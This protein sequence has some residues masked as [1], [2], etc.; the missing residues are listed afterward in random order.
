MDK[1]SREGT[2]PQKLE[3]DEIR[4]I[5]ALESRTFA[6]RFLGFNPEFTLFR[7]GFSLCVE[8]IHH[9]GDIPPKDELDRTQRD[10]AC[11][12]LDSLWFAEH[13]V[14]RGYENQ[15][16]VL[17][18]RGYETTSLMAYFINYP[19]KVK[20]WEK[21][22]MIRQSL[23]RKALASAPVPEPKEHLDE[24]YRVYSLFA[25]VNR[26]T[27]YHRLLGEEN[28]LTLGC[29]G[30]VSDEVVG[31]VLRELLRQMMWFV[32]VV[33]FVFAKFGVRLSSEYGQRMVAYRGQVQQLARALPPLFSE[34]GAAA[35]PVPGRS[36]N[37]QKNPSLNP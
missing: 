29:Q 21:G 13:A 28:R 1:P 37:G 27:V 15:A 17:L 6:K 31:Q 20:E 11:D 12:T 14:L 18:R 36:K 23:I 8:L 9:L 4:T 22:K 33:N 26:D 16:L 35:K 32:D 7:K 24:M 3:V 2:T 30:N 25:H 34:S 19:D 5:E 10:L